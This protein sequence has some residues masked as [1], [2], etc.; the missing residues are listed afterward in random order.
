MYKFLVNSINP[1]TIKKSDSN[2]NSKQ[3]RLMKWHIV[4]LSVSLFDFKQVMQKIY[5]WSVSSLKRWVHVPVVL[6]IVRSKIFIYQISQHKIIIKLNWRCSRKM[7]YLIILFQ[8]IL[9]FESSVFSSIMWPHPVILTESS[10]KWSCTLPAL[11]DAR[12]CQVVQF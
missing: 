5:K 3:E 8:D 2:S 12:G 6:F 10:S 11:L 4:R 7:K 9:E 1:M